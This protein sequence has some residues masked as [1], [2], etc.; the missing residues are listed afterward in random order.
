MKKYILLLSLFIYGFASAQLSLE[1]FEGNWSPVPATTGT[2]TDWLTLDNGIGT[3]VQWVQQEHTAQYP[4]YENIA[5]SHSAFLNVEDV[6]GGSAQDHLVSPEFT[7]PANGQLYFYSRLLNAGNQGS[8]YKIKILP[9][10]S[11]AANLSSYVDLITWTEGQINP[12]QT[13][14]YLKTVPIPSAYVNT[15]VRIAFVMQGDNMDGWLI[16]WARVTAPCANPG[17][18]EANVT[19]LGTV[20]L[21]WTNPS[22]AS[23]WEIEIVS[24]DM[25]PTGHGIVYNGSLP[26][27]ATGTATGLPLTEAPFE[28]HTRYKFY[29]RALCADTGLSL[30]VGPLQ[31]TTAGLG[32]NCS[33]PLQFSQLPFSDRDNTA[34]FSEKPSMLATGCASS[35]LL[36]Y[37]KWGATYRYT[38]DFTGN[39][40]I[41]MGDQGPYAALFVFDE[42]QDIGSSCMDSRYSLSGITPTEGMVIESFPVIE[43]EDYYIMATAFNAVT[44]NYNL[45]VQE[46]TCGMPVGNMPENIGTDSATFSWNDPGG[47]SAWELKVQPAFAGFPTT[48]GSPVST[49]SG[50]AISGLT[51]GTHYEYYVRASCGNGVYSAWAGPYRFYT[52]IC[53]PVDQCIYTFVM[54][55]V[56]GDRWM[57]TLTVSQNGTPI[58]ILTGPPVNT[59]IAE[60]PVAVCPGVPLQIMWNTE[61]AGYDYS[62]QVGLTIENPFGQEIYTMPQ[63]PYGGLPGIVIYDEIPVCGLLCEAPTGLAAANATQ[64]SVDL[65]WSGP[66]T[67]NWEYYIVIVGDPAPGAGTAGTAVSVNPVTNVPLDAPGTNYE[68]YVRMVCA[69]GGYSDWSAPQKFSSAICTPGNSCPYTFTLLNVPPHPGDV[70]SGW[71]GS[72]MTIFQQ[73]VEVA[74]IGDAFTTGNS[75]TVQ[76]DLCDNMPFEIEWTSAGNEFFN[77]NRISLAVYNPMQQ[78]IFHLPPNT[79]ISIGTVIYN[80]IVDCDALPCLPPTGLYA[81]NTLPETADLGWDGLAS[82]N[83]E[84]YIVAGGSAA[85]TSATAGTTTSTN[86]AVGV[87]LDPSATNF[88]FYVRLVCPDTPAGYSDWAGPFNFYR[89]VACASEDRCSYTIELWGTTPYWGGAQ[90]LMYSIYQ[91]GVLVKKIYHHAIGEGPAIESVELCHGIPFELVASSGANKPNISLTDPFGEIAFILTPDPA[92]NYNNGD[93]LFSGIADCMPLDCLKPKQP[94]ISNILSTQVTLD[95]QET[96]SATSWQVWV[97][98]IIAAAPQAGTGG[99][100][101]T[102][103]PFVYGDDPG[104]TLQPASDYKFFVMSL[105]GNGSNSEIDGAF[106]THPNSSDME[107]TFQ[108]AVS[109]DICEGAI[110]VPVNTTGD[111]MQT[112]TGSTHYAYHS[113][114]SIETACTF[115]AGYPDVWY[116]F[117]ATSAVHTIDFTSTGGNYL[118]VFKGACNSLVQIYCDSSHPQA[119]L[120][121]L[122]PG[123]TYYIRISNYNTN[124]SPFQ[125][126]IRSAVAGPSISVSDNAY[127]VP[128]LVDEFLLGSECAAISNLNYRTGTNFGS[129]NG[130]GYF[131]RNGSD[132]PIQEGIILATGSIQQALGPWPGSTAE[133]DTKVWTGDPDLDAIFPGADA[134]PS[135]NASVIEFDLVPTSCR[136]AFDFVFASDIYGL[137]D[138]VNGNGAAIFLTGPSGSPQNVNIAVIPGTSVPV[139]TATIRSTNETCDGEN[140]GLMGE[141]AY[142]DP[143]NSTTGYSGY[144]V[145]MEASATVIA[146]QTYHLKIVIADQPAHFDCHNSAIFIAGKECSDVLAI[147]PDLIGSDAVCSDG[148]AVINSGLTSPQYS[149]TWFKDGNELTGETSSSLTVTATAP[150]GEGT[151]SVIASPQGS[152]CQREGEVT[153][154]FTEPITVSDPTDLTAC[155]TTGSA[156]FDLLQNTATMAGSNPNNYVIT[157]HASQEDA[158]GGTGDLALTYTNI[159]Q[160]L[161]QLFVR[162]EDTSGCAIFRTFNLI[163]QTAPQFTIAGDISLCTGSSGFLDVVAENFDLNDPDVTY[164]WK[165]GAGTLPYPTSGIPINS[166]G[167]YE[168]TVTR[169]GCSV[170]RQI[171]VNEI[172]APV[173]DLGGPYVVCANETRTIDIA[174]ANF[175]ASQAMYQWTVNGNN[176]AE[177]SASITITEVGSYTVSVTVGSCAPVSKTVEVTLSDINVAIRIDQFCEDEA[178][179]LKATD[180]NSSFEPSTATYAW[181][182][183]NG[184]TAAI[185]QIAPAVPGLYTV[186]V[187]TADGCTGTRS[188]DVQDTVCFMQRGISPNNDGLNDTFDL[189]SMDVRKLT[190]FNRYGAVAY[191]RANYR[192]EWGGQASNGNDLPTGT[193]F[194]MIE[195]ANGE[196]L[197]GWI[198]LNRED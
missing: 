7:V 79:A 62:Q 182:G 127:T 188:V 194:Y 185:Q 27:T 65:S 129:N 33:Y 187:S 28:P 5:G 175:D 98:P 19:G 3:T 83:W 86:P 109:N 184:F 108:T 23:Q 126:C 78:R 130:I 80:G 180:E 161:Q 13:N 96:G 135:Y 147:G 154:A 31:F 140:P 110:N 160:N 24:D 155:S 186:V 151:Y 56:V 134:E 59:T 87:A 99:I 120:S 4:S 29:V 77:G 57:E 103:K 55:D 26:Y 143:L 113:Q 61:G 39:V 163:T 156:T 148:Q 84:Y 102:S 11:N 85:P 6:T 48:A 44:T 37:G 2:A 93:V 91:G 190:I 145:A 136:V 172:P 158:Q 21:L 177:T 46:V 22:G 112:I 157:Y 72:Y 152:G 20:D 30:W 97:L 139:S 42:C 159:V 123:E 60:Q 164:T 150:F 36:G 137:W 141:L 191:E 189:T 196:Q 50:F 32:D 47:I 104:E 133:L 138:C 71:G 81:A 69:N 16:D 58:A 8:S 171:T 52:A 75:L 9:A 169:G 38:A 49:N 35:G 121:N 122:I 197:T 66:S 92:Q 107:Y 114:L 165:L 63:A 14:Y 95:W 144:T 73:G 53:E 17:G 51:A 115:P 178:F 67:G 111:C 40:R 76:I 128:Q 1:K 106:I 168:V 34:N 64:N 174:A 192:N 119:L 125:L 41:E 18:F 70:S 89:E 132:F 167:I 45:L 54:T 15:N 12:V 43:G 68:F 118:G 162:I 100:T 131:N 166:P 146:G 74:R 116:S 105:C 183:P 153:V 94:E 170:S 117:E 195:R 124:P 198:Y 82:G 176:S 101:V 181:S 10:G 149:F 193:Y 25:M 173:F 90:P 88:D 179:Q 142:N